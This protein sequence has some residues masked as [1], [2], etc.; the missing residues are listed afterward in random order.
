MR[1]R[2]TRVCNSG[3]NTFSVFVNA[4][5]PA[6]LSL[7]RNRLDGYSSSSLSSRSFPIHLCSTHPLALGG[8]STSCIEKGLRD[9]NRMTLDSCCRT[10]SFCTIPLFRA[11]RCSQ[12]GSHNHTHATCSLMTC[13][14]FEE[15]VSMPVLSSDLCLVG[16]LL[17]CEVL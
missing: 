6:C 13:V 9:E 4:S 5:R 17:S 15:S 7:P 2:D 10:R 16:T 14:S 11:L 3:R 1:S 12:V 8:R